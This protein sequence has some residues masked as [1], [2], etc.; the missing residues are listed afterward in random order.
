M[1]ICRVGTELCHADRRTDRHDEVN[2]LLNFATCNMTDTQKS[3]K[4]AVRAS[5][6]S[7]QVKSATRFTTN[8]IRIYK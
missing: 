8:Q 4:M 2:T 1:K 3:L 5:E 7:L 6:F